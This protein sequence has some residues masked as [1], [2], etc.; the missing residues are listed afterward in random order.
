[1]FNETYS[2]LSL[3][4][5]VNAVE[6]LALEGSARKSRHKG[7]VKDVSMSVEELGAGVCSLLPRSTLVLT[8]QLPPYFFTS[9]LEGK[10]TL[11]LHK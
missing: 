2:E 8:R 5:N 6:G 9:T 10:T 11:S 3:V 1:M 7:T 4:L